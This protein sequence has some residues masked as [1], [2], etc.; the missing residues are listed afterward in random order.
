MFRARSQ[1]GKPLCAFVSFWLHLNES[2]PC[3]PWVAASP[4]LGEPLSQIRIRTRMVHFFPN[5]ASRDL[6]SLESSMAVA[7]GPSPYV[8]GQRSNE[9]QSLLCVLQRFFRGEFHLQVVDCGRAAFSG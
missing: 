9:V 4:R 5:T 1:F 3:P 7:V 8:V 6:E 2:T